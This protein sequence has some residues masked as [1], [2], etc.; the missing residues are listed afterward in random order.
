MINKAKKKTAAKQLVAL[1]AGLTMA[2]GAG[3]GGCAYGY[4]PY[5][6]DYTYYDPYYY[7]YDTYYAYT[8]VDPI[9]S[10]YYALSG[11][12]AT[13]P[14]DLNAWASTMASRVNSYY[15]SGCATAT[16]SGA[17]VAYAFNNCVGPGGKGSTSGNISVALTQAASGEVTIT[18]TSSDLTVNG[19]RY[20]LDMSMVPSTSNGQSAI[21]ITS[22]SYSP[23]RFDSRDAQITLSWVQGS[24][25]FDANGTS[26]GTRGGMNATATLSG[27]H[28][29]TNMC[30][31]A[32]TISVAAPKGA[33]T[34]TFNGSDQFSVAGPD[35]TTHSYD[36]NCNP[37]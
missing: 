6:Y 27:Y 21:A 28:Q 13:T 14:V 4:D 15:G 37:Q 33:F 22:K 24:G 36:M 18:A 30:P 1:A 17:T 19:E 31:S 11:S 10:D 3:A 16:A 29:C 2:V 9:Y 34:S 23:S 5:Y 7:G 26:Q 35:G 32:G 20:V 12:G 8:W 25:C